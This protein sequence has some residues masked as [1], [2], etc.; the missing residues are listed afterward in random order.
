[1]SFSWFFAPETPQKFLR[2]P[3]RSEIKVKTKTLC[4][5]KLGIISL[6]PVTPSDLIVLK[7]IQEHSIREINFREWK[8]AFEFKKGAVE[9]LQEVQQESNFKSCWIRFIFW[10]VKTW[11]MFTWFLYK[12]CVEQLNKTL[13]P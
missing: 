8:N 6:M 12:S 13:R 5:A 2:G 10:L 3:N 4:M 9:M 1:M 7:Q 11:V